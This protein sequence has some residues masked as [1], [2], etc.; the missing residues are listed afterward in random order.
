M[1]PRPPKTTKAKTTTSKAP[2]KRSTKPP[3]APTVDEVE[4]V[5]QPTLPTLELPPYHG[6]NPKGMRTSLTGAGSR[7]TRSHGI[8]DRV[9]LVVEAKV[10]SAG[11][12]DTDD[13]LIYEEKLKVLDLYELDRD[14]GARLLSTVRSAYRTADDALNGKVAAAHGG[15]DLTDVGYTDASGVVLTPKEIAALRG[16]PVR[17]L[18]TEELTPAV[19]EWSDGSRELWPDDFAKDAPR[20]TVGDMRGDV[21]VEALLHHETGEPLGKLPTL[22]PLVDDETLRK[23]ASGANNVDEDPVPAFDEGVESWE[24]KDPPRPATKAEKAAERILPTAQ[25]FDEVNVSIP[26]LATV[27]GELLDGTRTHRGKLVDHLSR[28]LEA[29]KQGRG[30]AAK[31]RSGAMDLISAA[32]DTAKALR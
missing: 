18:I 22:P 10:R 25:D 20:P 8:G 23:V 5:A 32:I 29:E 26:R 11:H 12:V 9:V 30:V 15:V 24:P 28:L 31:Y 19:V 17:A 14:P 7:I 1:A 2:R 13:G 27:I 3:P 4:V 16:D 21:H 6:R